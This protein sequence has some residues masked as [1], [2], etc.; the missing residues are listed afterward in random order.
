[1]MERQCIS[2]FCEA[3]ASVPQRTSM[4]DALANRICLRIPDGAKPR[5]RSSGQAIAKGRYRRRRA[6]EQSKR[7]PDKVCKKEIYFLRLNSLC[8]I[9]VMVR[10]P[11]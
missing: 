7:Y 6:W 3:S 5:L 8:P 11:Q 2:G 1:M 4:R 9:E 10:R